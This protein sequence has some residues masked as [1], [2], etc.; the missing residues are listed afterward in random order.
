[1][2]KGPVQIAT[3]VLFSKPFP[4]FRSVSVSVLSRMAWGLLLFSN[5]A[6]AVQ[7]DTNLAMSIAR[8]QDPFLILGVLEREYLRLP[9]DEKKLL[10]KNRYSARARAFHPDQFKGDSEKDLATQAIQ[11][12]NWAREEFQAGRAVPRRPVSREQPTRR[13]S[14]F[15]PT[16]YDSGNSA[17]YHRNRLAL[18]RKI[19]NF[20]AELKSLTIVFLREFELYLKTGTFRDV[21]FLKLEFDNAQLEYEALTEERLLKA[22]SN[23]Q[24][25]L[26]DA[27][28]RF[29]RSILKSSLSLMDQHIPLATSNA[30]A[31]AILSSAQSRVIA[32]GYLASLLLDRGVTPGFENP[33]IAVTIFDRLYVE[34][35]DFQFPLVAKELVRIGKLHIKPETFDS[36]YPL[37]IDDMQQSKST[38]ERCDYILRKRIR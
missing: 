23:L 27:H 13:Y 31:A 35:Q 2:L 32:H 38:L 5:V 33:K 29:Q 15:D 3:R 24:D 14:H 17:A 37:W 10:V 28:I 21:E 30:E 18:I 16:T 12:I 26:M 11:K 1:M 4:A 9:D 8:S 7:L 22:E 6:L 20:K 19:E 36:L 34:A 25:G